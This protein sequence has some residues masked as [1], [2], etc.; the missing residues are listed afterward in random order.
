MARDL[1]DNLSHALVFIK[2]VL[3]K[4]QFPVVEEILQGPTV[5]A[6]MPGVDEEI[7]PAFLRMVKNHGLRHVSLPLAKPY[8]ALSFNGLERLFLGWIT[9]IIAHGR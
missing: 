4:T 9:S 1:H 3:G 8:N 7:R 6:K 2:I 5:S